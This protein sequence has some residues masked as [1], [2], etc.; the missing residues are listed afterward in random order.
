MWMSIWTAKAE[1]NDLLPLPDTALFKQFCKI[2]R[3]CISICS[4]FVNVVVV[5]VLC[6]VVKFAGL[7]LYWRYSKLD[8]LKNDKLKWPCACQGDINLQWQ[9]WMM[10]KVY[11]VFTNSILVWIFL[12]ASSVWE[13]EHMKFMRNGTNCFVDFSHIIRS[14]PV[15][16]AWDDYGFANCPT[17]VTAQPFFNFLV[18][19]NCSSCKTEIL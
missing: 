13:R 8:A 4:Y 19:E 9:F 15:P 2:V 11:V 1:N 12:L 10:S 17:G 7:F 6:G 16:E 18:V 5:A 14:L 3:A